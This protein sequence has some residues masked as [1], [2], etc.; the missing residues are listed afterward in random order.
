[1]R[2]VDAGW[3]MRAPTR[4]MK[5]PNQV[6]ITHYTIVNHEAH[7]Q[8]ASLVFVSKLQQ[9]LKSM[10]VVTDLLSSISA[11]KRQRCPCI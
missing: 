10:N 4:F 3:Y 2:I 5:L 9:S 1:M 11:S 8:Y 6:D 7:I